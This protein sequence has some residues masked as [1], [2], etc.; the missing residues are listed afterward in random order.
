GL[1]EQVDPGIGFA[2]FRVHF[3]LNNAEYQDELLVFLGASY[4]RIVARGQVYGL[5][6]RGLA[7]NT[8]TPGGEE[9]P[10][11]TE[12]WLG[13]PAAYSTRLVI[14]AL[15]DSRSV[16]GAYRFDLRPGKDSVVSVRSRLFARDD[17]TKL[18]IAPLTSMFFYGS[19]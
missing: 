12:F 6:A 4:F 2:G 13:R 17:V 15:L 3:P 16:T 10:R 18:G 5:S 11:F 8:A 19:D 7:V 1:G 14:H 9:F